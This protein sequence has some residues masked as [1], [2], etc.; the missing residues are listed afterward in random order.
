MRY[1]ATSLVLLGPL[2][3]QQVV[4]PY[5]APNLPSSARAWGYMTYDTRALEMPCTQIACSPTGTLYLRGDGRLFYQGMFSGGAPLPL[6][7]AGTHITDIS[8]G[9]MGG[10]ALFSDGS[11]MGFGAEMSFTSY[12]P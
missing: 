1:L 4:Q 3:G 12:V 10:L 7:P 6:A 2:V 5:Q 11:V 9:E 8:L